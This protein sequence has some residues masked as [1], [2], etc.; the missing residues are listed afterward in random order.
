MDNLSTLARDYQLK[1]PKKLFGNWVK[2]S[3]LRSVKN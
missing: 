2:S 1:E 3:E